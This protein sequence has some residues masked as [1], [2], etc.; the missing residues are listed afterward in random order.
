MDVATAINV[1]PSAAE[2]RGEIVG[3]GTFSSDCFAFL[4]AFDCSLVSSMRM[5]GYLKQIADIKLH[6]CK[7]R[8]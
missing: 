6:V 4:L 3:T 1:S 8:G 7:Y 2:N 5:L